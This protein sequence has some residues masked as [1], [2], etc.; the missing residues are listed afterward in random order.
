MKPTA[1]SAL[2]P[3]SNAA[4][5]TREIADR[6]RVMRWWFLVSLVLV[7]FSHF[8]PIARHFSPVF[9]SIASA[10]GGLGLIVGTVWVFLARATM[11]K[12]D[13]K[14]WAFGFGVV[15]V[16]VLLVLALAVPTPTPFQYTVFRV[17]LALAAAGI[18]G[19]FP[20]FLTVNVPGW[21]RAGGALAIFFLVYFYAPAA[22]RAVLEETQLAQP[23]TQGTR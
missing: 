10:A 1:V 11:T 2:P 8:T 5:E 21:V 7:V 12:S 3:V 15:F 6:L 13:E 16:V 18:A 4:I 17:I 14:K 20:G 9:P 22:L 23:A 19:M